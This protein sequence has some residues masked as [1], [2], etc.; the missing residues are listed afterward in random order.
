MEQTNITYAQDFLMKLVEKRQLRKFC[1]ANG[2]NHSQIY[3]IAIGKNFPSYRT[4]CSMSNVISPL[5]WFFNVGETIPY[6]RTC[7]P[8]LEGTCKFVKEHKLQYKELIKKYDLSYNTAYNIFSTETYTPTFVM[9]LKMKMDVN[10]IEF[11]ISDVSPDSIRKPEQG[12]IVSYNQNNYLIISDE[13]FQ[14][15][16][17]KIAGCILV[18]KNPKENC[19]LNI[20]AVTEYDVDS[21]VFLKPELESMY[22][23]GK[24]SDEKLAEILKLVRDI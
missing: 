15:K 22:I 21:V 20:E 10:P 11:F 12:D 18:S 5:D 23:L 14:A 3:Y 16:H 2:W 8:P 1:L 9:I 7:V 19:L 13:T 24:I 4:I 6:E 17:N